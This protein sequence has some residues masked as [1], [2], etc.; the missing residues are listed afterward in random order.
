MDG[1]DYVLHQA[2][3]PS[4]SRSVKD[5]LTTNSVNVEGT[6]NVLMASRDA[7]VKRVVYGSSSSTYDDTPVLPKHENM[8]S[9]HGFR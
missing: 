1:V 3:V 2:A 6:L 5:P 8:Y 7:D 9:P 4:V